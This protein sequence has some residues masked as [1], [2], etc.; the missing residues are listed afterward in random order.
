MIAKAD[1][2]DIAQDQLIPALQRQQQHLDLIDKWY[3][4]DPEGFELP[5][6]ATEEH[7]R[8]LELARTPW[9]GLVVTNVSQSMYVDGYK[10]PNKGLEALPWRIFRANKLTGRQPAFHRSF[11][12]Y[13][14]SYATILPGVDEVTGED[15]PT[16]RGIS[17]RKGLA[18]YADP[19]SDAWPLMFIQTGV[20][21]RGS[22]WFRVIDEEA[23]H[24]LGVEQ[25][26]D[27]KALTYIE[28][29]LHGAQ[30]PP[31]V[32]FC[33]QLDLD[34]RS[35]GEVEPFIPVAKR[36][37]KASYDRLLAQHFGSFKVRWAT[38]LDDD[39]ADDDDPE[40]PALTPEQQAARDRARLVQMRH[41]SILTS[42]SK[43]ATFGTLPETQLQ[44][45]IASEQHEI[46][47]LAAVTQTPVHAMTG[48][49][50]NLSAEALEAARSTLT[51]KVTERQH[52]TG[53]TWEQALRMGCHL[54]RRDAEAGDFE[55][56]VTWADTRI[57]SL[58]QA[59]DS[60]G[61][62][63][64]QLRVPP[65]ALWSR[66]PGVTQTDIEEWRRM[67]GDRPAPS[68]PAPAV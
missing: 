45:L 4:W 60:L 41:S 5:H 23:V 54:L 7:R 2:L 67:V 14:T 19:A 28:H 47:T 20:D 51:A 10:T 49:L 37:N 22:R 43:D 6:G 1:V 48:D 50:I 35:P 21:G 39:G 17:P 36:A 57:R 40:A 34:G 25:A 42:T 63:A 29:R 8:L 65:D 12:A 66:I 46:Q 68:A 31:V 61:K 56:H 15:M 33:N 16:I 3:R 44:P 53:E 13:G 58:S 64:A 62:I 27:K 38:G 55:G 11:L 9:L 26:G 30:V 52:P 24:H 32:R 59:A 18:F